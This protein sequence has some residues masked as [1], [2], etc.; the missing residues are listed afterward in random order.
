[1]TIHLRITGRFADW[2]LALRS[3]PLSKQPPRPV[4]EVWK[5]RLA[6]SAVRPY[7][8][9]VFLSYTSRPDEVAILLPLIARFREDLRASLQSFDIKDVLF[10]DAYISGVRQAAPGAELPALQ[11]EVSASLCMVCF[12]SPGHTQSEWCELEWKAMHADAAAYRCRHCETH[13]L[14]VRW[15]EAGDPAPLDRYTER[16]DISACVNDT[17][18]FDTEAW[19]AFI[20]TAAEFVRHRVEHCQAER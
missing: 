3:G 1:M 7:K 2:V 10:L 8:Y 13:I 6:A 5:A 18:Y 12:L 15:K 17:A 11:R 16:C 9:H 19:A 4:A 14:P 20:R